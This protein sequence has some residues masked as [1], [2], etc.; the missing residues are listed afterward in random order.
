MPYNYSEEENKILS[1][2]NY[3]YV[4]NTNRYTSSNIDFQKALENYF[5]TGCS[6][7][8][9]EQFIQTAYGRYIDSKYATPATNFRQEWMEV[10]VMQLESERE[11]RNFKRSQLKPVFM[12]DIALELVEGMITQSIIPQI[13]CAFENARLVNQYERLK[14]I[15]NDM[16]FYKPPSLFSLKSFVPPPPKKVSGGQTSRHVQRLQKNKTRRRDK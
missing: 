11:P 9:F 6:D 8:E 14:V 5:K 4:D 1:F 10:D 2:L 13:K 15:K 16:Y 3:S 12:I 7:P